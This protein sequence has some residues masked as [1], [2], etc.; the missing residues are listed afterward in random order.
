M[1][2]FNWEQ[3]LRH[4]KYDCNL[5]LNV[6]KCISRVKKATTLENIIILKSMKYTQHNWLNKPVELLALKATNNEK[7]IYISIASKRNYFLYLNK[8]ISYLPTYYLEDELINK[9]KLNTLLRI[10]NNK[11]LFDY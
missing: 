5:S 9:L 4:T 11:I 8:N 10:E 3:I 6:I 1:I 7:C 2:F